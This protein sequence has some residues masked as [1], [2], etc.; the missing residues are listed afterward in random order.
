MPMRKGIVAVVFVAGLACSLLVACAAH[1]SPR[2][3]PLPQSDVQA[4]ID[5]YN[6]GQYAEAEAALRNNPDPKARAYLAASLA[7]LKRYAEAE[8]V[9]KQVLES[10]PTDETAVGALGHALVGQ[11]K[12]DEAVARLSA[13]IAAKP[14]LAYAYYW[15]GQAYEKQ[16]KVSS[17]ADDFQA[18]LKLAPNAPEAKLVQ[19]V[20]AGLR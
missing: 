17:M 6:A 13:A 7:K 12:T 20:L 10:S 3:A 15:R 14:D 8:S 4:G 9:A 1:A 16:K 18:F 5:L 2:P 11:E 19:A